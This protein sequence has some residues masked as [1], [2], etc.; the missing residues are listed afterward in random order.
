MLKLDKALFISLMIVILVVVGCLGYVIAT[1]N[2]GEKFTEF[3][4]LGPDGK[5]E[6]YPQQVILGKSVDVIIGVV[7]HEHRP[8]SYRVDI[9]VDGVE[10]S[11]VNIGTLAHEERW[12]ERVSFIPQ[13]TG[14]NR[15]VEFHLYKNGEDE[16]YFKDPLRL[17]VDVVTF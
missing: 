15:K 4:I 5:T 14:E 16:P 12:G 3:Y 10:D 1:P 2:Q 8:V 6:E 7:N 13:V 9:T 17:Y 11:Q